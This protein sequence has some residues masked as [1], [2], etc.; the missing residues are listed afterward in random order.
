MRDCLQLPGPQAQEPSQL[1]FPLGQSAAVAMGFCGWD[2]IPA[3]HVLGQALGRGTGILPCFRA[4]EW[5][6]AYSEMRDAGCV[7][8]STV[9]SVWLSCR[10]SLTWLC[11]KETL[12]H[13]FHELCIQVAPR[14]ASA[15]LQVD[16]VH[17]TDTHHAT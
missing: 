17:S 6:W 15:N 7:G 10:T 5:A 3:S 11:V 14:L 4:L 8:K 16:C 13:Q 12:V 1:T 2:G 9:S